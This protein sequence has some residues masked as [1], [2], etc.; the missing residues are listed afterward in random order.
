[1]DEKGEGKKISKPNK[2]CDKA[3]RELIIQTIQETLQADNTK[4]RS[5]DSIIQSVN[6]VNSEFLDSFF[7]VGFTHNGELIGPLANM[8]SQR[9]E[10]AIYNVVSNTIMGQQPMVN[11]AHLNSFDDIDFDEYDDLD[12]E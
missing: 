4:K 1:M 9:D 8:K 10:S 11:G 2:A 5:V 7:I 3:I 6:S 12:D